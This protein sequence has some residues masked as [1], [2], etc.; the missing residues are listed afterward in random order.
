M[1]DITIPEGALAAH[2]E[3]R[4]L[5][6]LTDVLLEHEGADPTNPVARSLAW[7]FVHRPAAVLVAGEPSGDP[8][9]RVVASVPEGQYDDERRSA[10]V[11]AVT[12]AV[13]D[14]E[15]GTRSRDPDRVWVFASEVADGTWG[16][17]GRV[18][19]LGDIVG[20]VLGNIEIGRRYA[21][22]RLGARRLQAGHPAV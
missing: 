11:A 3:R 19:R 10:M 6:R 17:G 21:A 18:R 16:A 5:H 2:A 14:A 15:G 9:Y 12:D 13:L 20:M 22:A 7:I 8:R 4:L 1:I